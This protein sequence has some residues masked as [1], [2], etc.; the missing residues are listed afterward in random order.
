MGF[1]MTRARL[2]ELIAARRL[3]QRE[4]LV[5][6]LLRDLPHPIGIVDAGDADA[7]HHRL[8]LV[9]EVREEAQGIT[10][11]VGDARDQAGYQYLAG[12]HFTVQFVHSIPRDVPAIWPPWPR[13]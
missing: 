2:P 13:P 4:Q 10:L 7:L 5:D 3:H 12:E 6:R 11:L 1:V 9:A 8:D